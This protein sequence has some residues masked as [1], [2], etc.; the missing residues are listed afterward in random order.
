MVT[1]RSDVISVFAV[2]ALC[3]AGCGET[4]H[5]VSQPFVANGGTEGPLSSGLWG[6]TSSGPDG[7]HL[8]CIS[9]RHAALAITLR[10]RSS[11]A[12]TLTGAHGSEPAP[13]IIRRV[14]VQFRLAPPPPT[15][16]FFVSNLRRWSASAPRPVTIPPGRDAVVQSNFLMGRCEDIGP[17]QELTVNSAVVVEYRA[18]GHAGRQQVAQRSARILLSQGP[19]IRGCAPPRRST[20]LVA[21]GLPCTVVRAAALGCRRWSYGH[22]GRCSAAGHDWDCTSTLGTGSGS[23]ERCWLGTKRQ[24]LKIRWAG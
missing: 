4:S 2:L 16:D 6:D 22:S 20:S 23:L 21:V 5:L 24:S 11:T 15:G 1:G 8:G 9:G 10:N 7:M 13:L 3:G 19:A 12:V 14:A 17:R 18:S